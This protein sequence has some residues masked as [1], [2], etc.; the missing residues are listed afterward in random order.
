MI[1]G[2]RFKAAG[3]CGLVILF[4]IAV[5]LNA[6]DPPATPAGVE[7][8]ARGPVHE[9]FAQPTVGEPQAGPVAAKEP[10]KA[11]D[12]LP[13]D[14]RPEG[15][16]V[17]WIPGYWSWDDEASD[18]VWVSGVWRMAPAG[19]RWIP[20]H[21]QPVDKGWQW[22]AGIWAPATVTEA[23]YL[24]PPPASLDQG[25]SAPA[26]DAEST[27]VPGIWVY[28]KT[29]YFWRPGFWV[30]NQP[31]WVW[32]PAYYTWT[33]SG[34]MYNDGYW[35]HPFEQR[36]LLFA[37]V[38][39]GVGWRGG[40]YTPRFVVSADF[41]LGALFV[42]PAGCH[43]YFGDYFEP[44]YATRGFVAWPEYRIG[45]V[46]FDPNFAYYRHLHVA[47]P[48]WE[49]ALHNLYRAR[50]AGEV[51]R[52]PRTLLLQTAAVSAFAGNKTGSVV[53]HK[54]IHL[55][56][57]QNV[58][59]LAPLKEVHELHVTGLSSLSGVKVTKVP[60]HVVKLEAIS[61]E[62]HAREVKSAVVMRESAIQRRE[63]EAKILHEKGGPIL[64]TDPPRTVRL[65]LP[66]PPPH[67][68][69]VRPVIKAVPPLPVHPVHEERPIPKKK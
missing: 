58:T 61:R 36:G 40:P 35:D 46:G 55:T 42:H 25:P 47:E 26:P 48:L 13:P 65:A 16:N 12:E 6:E 29:R 69:A 3:L 5:R 49:P 20:G 4:G 21:W 37:P 8:L 51:P 63:V 64:H 34:Y 9:A 50:L 24:A 30:H 67:V 39:F 60:E 19:R 62:E 23:Q 53:I 17:E 1:S 68:V 22:V 7:V 28:Q 31:N 11:I 41:L 38:R 33:P 45:R 43:Y 54:D 57:V 10:P 59:V 32:C 44:R 15:D 52:P 56:N 66:E 18:Y 27:Y 14:Q 2:R